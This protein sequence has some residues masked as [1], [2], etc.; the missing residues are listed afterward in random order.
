[1]NEL[2]IFRIKLQNI[3][4]PY[5]NRPLT[6]NEIKLV[7]AA[8]NRLVEEYNHFFEYCTINISGW[9]TL[10]LYDKLVYTLLGLRKK[11]KEKVDLDVFVL[12]KPE[13]MEMWG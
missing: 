11:Q 9:A 10:P 1:M 6:A 13:Y 7:T 12:P 2:E 3:L 4:E 5:L 8:C